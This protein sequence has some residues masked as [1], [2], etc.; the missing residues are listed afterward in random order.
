[1]RPIRRKIAK[2]I[3]LEKETEKFSPL[4]MRFVLSSLL[5]WI[6]AMVVFS[7]GLQGE[8]VGNVIGML[9]GG[10]VFGT[11]EQWS[12][13]PEDC[14]R[15]FGERALLGKV[16]E[17]IVVAPLLLLILSFSQIFSYMMG[18]LLALLFGYVISRVE[19]VMYG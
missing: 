10:V 3:A 11:F 13:A 6:F 14:G 17:L 16:I 8:E 19:E 7:Y 15:I 5:L 12:I 1:M 9:M 2:R 18:F 4:V